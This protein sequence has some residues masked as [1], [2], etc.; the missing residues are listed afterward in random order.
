MQQQI[1]V[2]GLHEHARRPLLA[3]RDEVQLCESQQQLF[4]Y[5]LIPY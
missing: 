2:V 5:S 3:A 4:L 1:N